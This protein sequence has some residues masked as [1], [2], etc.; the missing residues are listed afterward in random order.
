MKKSLFKSTILVLAFAFTALT[1]IAQNTE[2]LK[3]RIEKINKEMQQAMISGQSSYGHYAEDAVSLP[4]YG[5]MAQ[6]IDAIKKSYADM[7]AGGAKITAF[8]TQIISLSTCTNMIAEIGSYKMTMTMPGMPDPMQ[9]AGKY[10]TIWEQQSDGSLK[11]K[12]EM[13]N[14][15]SYPTGGN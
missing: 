5:K 2:E 8:E 11:V 14:A 10:L 9:D 3:A 7:M 12:L 1:A 15:D 6:G 4:N 13:W